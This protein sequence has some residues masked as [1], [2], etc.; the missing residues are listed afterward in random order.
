[1]IRSSRFVL[2]MILCAWS[3]PLASAQPQDGPTGPDPAADPA[4]AQPGT[5]DP[6]QT[7][8][9]TGT[10]V[11]QS[12]GEPVAFATVTVSGVDDSTF[13]AENG[14]FTF[15]NVP[16]GRHRVTA[17]FGS[18]SATTVA[19]DVAPAET[20]T[21]RLS[22]RSGETIF[23]SGSILPEAPIDMPTT[24][25]VVGA[26]GIEQAGASAPYEAVKDVPGIDFVGVG[27][28]DQRISVRGFTTQFN[29]RFLSMMDGR[30]ATLPGAGIPQGNLMPTSRMDMK[31]VEVII[32]PA[33]ARYGAN[34]HGGVINV[35]S[36]TP[37][38]ESGARVEVRGRV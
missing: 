1:V 11:D 18:G 14:T 31:A 16:A 28:S 6:G 7:G 23:V 17:V 10:V 32:G 9:I 27:L 26:K 21:V 24:V 33:S 29:S 3:A 25:S 13:T 37:W 8:A 19:V 4:P 30:L 5:P 34:A 38:D 12:T 2:V 35:L 22:V 36:K 15:Q 20:A